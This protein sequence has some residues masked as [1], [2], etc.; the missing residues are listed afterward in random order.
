MWAVAIDAYAKVD[1]DD[2][3]RSAI[4]AASS[5]PSS[6]ALFGAQVPTLYP[7][8]YGSCSAGSASQPIISS[9]FE[10]TD[11]CRITPSDLASYYGLLDKLLSGL[12][13]QLGGAAGTLVGQVTPS[14]SGGSSLQDAIRA[15]LSSSAASQ[16]LSGVGQVLL[17]STESSAAIAALAGA[18]VPAAA[19]EILAAFIELPLIAKATLDLAKLITSCRSF[20]ASSACKDGGC[21]ATAPNCI[22]S[23][24]PLCPSNSCV[25]GI[26]KGATCCNF[27]TGECCSDAD[28]CPSGSL[29]CHCILSAGYS[30]GH[31]QCQ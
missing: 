18:E 9:P 22:V 27:N 20:T 16:L 23:P 31:C 13:G 6:T 19:L 26:L 28:C 21:K 2:T 4:V 8:V 17:T 29:T 5:D 12:I 10:C 11:D 7:S 24:G 15:N 1:F 3:A 25:S 30:I 14:I